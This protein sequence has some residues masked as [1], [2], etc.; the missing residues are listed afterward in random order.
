M[1]FP[2]RTVPAA[3]CALLFLPHIVLGAADSGAAP[4]QNDAAS[5]HLSDPAA[6]TAKTQSR[7]KLG[8]NISLL[9]GFQYPAEAEKSLSESDKPVPPD[10]KDQLHGETPGAQTSAWAATMREQTEPGE[11][12]LAG[13][14]VMPALC[15]VVTLISMVI[16]GIILNRYRNDKRTLQTAV[17]RHR[18]PEPEP[19]RNLRPYGRSKRRVPGSPTIHRLR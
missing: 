9:P 5:I 7:A 14:I 19:T 3:A 18:R 15:A 4:S 10:P 8:Q 6:D 16:L 13:R 1:V 12:G 2:F 17:E 11:E